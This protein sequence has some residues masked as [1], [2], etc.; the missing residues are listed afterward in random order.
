MRSLI[1]AF[2]TIAA[3]AA[4]AD[5][6]RRHGKTGRAPLPLALHGSKASVEKMYG[7]ARLHRM[8]FYLTQTNVDTA[9]A[10]GRLVPLSGD[11]AYEMTRGVGF[12]YATRETKAFV[13]AFARQFA[14]ACDSPLTVTSAAR[15]LNRQPRNANPHSVHPAGIAVDI[16]RPPSGPCLTWVRGALATL[17]AQGIVE[18]TEERRPVHLH[19]AVL[20]APG[21][22]VILPP[23]AATRPTISSA[24]FAKD[25]SII[26]WNWSGVNRLR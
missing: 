9:I 6:Q 7:F 1:L 12:S 8:P 13:S 25:A 11:A 22:P 2:A 3:L 21:A 17:E 10:R 14:M 19:I 5:A 16:R 26:D 4:R 20:V 18:A 15:P 23:M 24:L